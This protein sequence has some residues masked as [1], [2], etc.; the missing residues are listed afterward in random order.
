MHRSATHAEWLI[1]LSGALL[2]ACGGTDSTRIGDGS[3]E[4]AVGGLMPQPSAAPASPAPSRD[5]AATPDVAVTPAP[6]ADGPPSSNTA[7]SDTAPSIEPPGTAQ[8]SAPAGPRFLL[9]SAVDGETD[10]LNYFTPVESLSEPSVVAL[11][12]SLELSGR[13]R[14]YAEPGVGYFAIGEAEGVSLR[15][16]ELVDGKFVPGDALS[17]QAYGV[18]SL[19]AQAVLFVSPTRAY[20]KDSGQG[21]IIAWNP[22]DMLIERVIELPASL[23]REGYVMGVSDWARRD[24]EAFFAVGWSTP[25]YDRVLPGTTLVRLDLASGEITLADD[26]R[27]RGLQTAANLDGTVYFFSDVIN[28]FGDAVYPG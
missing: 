21:L 11:D 19:G 1:L 14:L 5:A 13:A 15:R 27:C 22:R 4:E 24:G 17:L 2:A 25:E 7:P 10:R 28:G 3:A 12:A 9:H 18:T 20:Y 6:S 8:P 26:L 23:T 16:Y